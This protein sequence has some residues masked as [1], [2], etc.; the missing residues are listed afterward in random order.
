MG[1]FT[2]TTPGDGTFVAEATTVVFELWGGCGLPSLWAGGGG[3]GGA[4]GGARQLVTVTGLTVGQTYNY[5]VG[6]A[7]E[8]TWVINSSTGKAVCGSP[9]GGANRNSDRTGGIGGL[10]A[11]CIGDAGQAFNGGSGGSGHATG[12]GGGGGS[13]AGSAADGQNGTNAGAGAAGV[14]GTAPTGGGSGGNGGGPGQNGA[15]GNAPGGG[16]GG[17]AATM[18]SGATKGGKIIATWADPGG[19]ASRPRRQMRN[20]ATSRA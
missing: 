7:G 15:D 17:G 8:D 10:A 20:R 4:S 14:G 16:P 5:H 18:V 19:S 9:A 3:Q 1:S 2:V 12:R 6:D 11:S 13:G